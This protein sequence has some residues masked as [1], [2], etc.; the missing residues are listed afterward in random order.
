MVHREAI[1][2]RVLPLSCST[3]ELADAWNTVYPDQPWTYASAVRNPWTRGELRAELDA[4]VADTYG[5]S[6]PEYARVLTGFPLLDRNEPPLPGDA[7]VTD[8]DD[9]PKGEQGIS[10]EETPYGRYEIKPR[11]F[12]TRDLALLTYMRRKGYAPPQRLDLF[13]R[14]E[15]GIDPVGPLSRF[16]IGEHKD[17]IDRVELA[18][19][20]GAVPYVPSGRSAG[21]SGRGA[22]K[23]EEDGK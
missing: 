12:I 5:L 6:V 21:T 8:A 1:L 10:W 13:F 3:P 7:F 17:L 23:A 14:E 20:A 18:R 9:E 19:Q 4:M 15:V 2:D 11:S 16:R 22:R